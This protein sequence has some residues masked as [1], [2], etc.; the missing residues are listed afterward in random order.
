MNPTDPRRAENQSISVVIPAYNHGRYIREAISSALSQGPCVLEVIV[1]DD[2]SRDDTADVARSVAATD[3]RVRVLSK[4]N[5]GP[6]P[7]RN[8]GWRSAKGRWIYFLDADDALAENALPD[9]L[10]AASAHA[11]LVIPYGFQEIYS[12]VLTGTPAATASMARKSGSLLKEIAGCYPGTIWTSL[13]PRECVEAIGGFTESDGVW[14]GEDFDYALK[15]AFRYPFLWVDRPVVKT[16]MH[17]SNRHRDFPSRE[18]F[19]RSIRR[20]FKGCWN[21]R[22]RWYALRGMSHFHMEYAHELAAQGKRAEARRS[23]LNAWI[24]LPTRLNNLRKA[25]L[26]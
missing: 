3:S 13:V 25:I 10:E 24:C 6:S 23:F 26:G 8:L 16:R 14:R 5:S 11:G 9:L 17:G 4:T 21:P 12:Q 1:V 2:G 22:L 19:L 7:T 20:T 15:L 18:G